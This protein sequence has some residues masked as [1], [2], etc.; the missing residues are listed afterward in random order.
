MR[1]ADASSDYDSFVALIEYLNKALR[2]NSTFFKTIF[3]IESL[4]IEVCFSDKNIL[5]T[6]FRKSV[7]KWCG[8]G[9]YILV[10]Y[11]IANS[12][13]LKTFEAAQFL[14]LV[15]KISEKLELLCSVN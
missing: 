12:F 10:H 14:K 7:F 4:N 3:E 8:S 15:D 11:S 6:D 5:P 2:N 13:S 1:T 9:I